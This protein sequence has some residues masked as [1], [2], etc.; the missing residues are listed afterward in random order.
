MQKQQQLSL[1][2]SLLDL[3]KEM[4]V[5][6]DVLGLLSRFSFAE[7]SFTSFII[8]TANP[9][10]LT[11]TSTKERHYISTSDRFCSN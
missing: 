11:L 9:E 4:K 1:V 6:L 8:K 7:V 10:C 3:Q 2:Q 5:V